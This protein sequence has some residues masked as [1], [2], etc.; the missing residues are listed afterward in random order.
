MHE[1]VAVVRML[2]GKQLAT[3]EVTVG[4]VIVIATLP[5]IVDPVT[6]V[7]FAVMVTIGFAGTVLGAE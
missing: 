6:L 2:A 5:E 1:E 3:T 4:G 7:D